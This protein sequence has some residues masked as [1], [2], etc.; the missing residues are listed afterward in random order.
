VEVGETVPIV[1]TASRDADGK[2]RLVGTA[3]APLVLAD[4]PVATRIDVP[5]A[6]LRP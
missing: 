3:A 4:D 5:S 6:T 1:A 2:L